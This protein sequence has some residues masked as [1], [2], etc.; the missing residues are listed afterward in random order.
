MSYVSLIPP[1]KV[2]L[3]DLIYTSC[4]DPIQQPA[5]AR[6]HK[7][8]TSPR[9]CQSLVLRL[10]HSR[11]TVLF[12]TADSADVAD[13]PVVSTADPDFLLLQLVHLSLSALAGRFYFLIIF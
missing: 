8:Y 5:A 4:T 11:I 10:F 9:L 6:T 12:S 2:P 7:L 13:P 1:R 3:E